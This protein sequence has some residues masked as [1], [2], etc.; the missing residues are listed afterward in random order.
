VIEGFYS[1]TGEIIFITGAET[2]YAPDALRIIVNHF[3]DPTV[4][5]A[6]GTMRVGNGVDRLSTKLETAYRSL[7]DFIRLAEG[8]M[9]APFDIKGEIAASRR[10]VCQHLVEN[11]E[12]ARKG[13]ID[14]SV[15]FQAKKDGY[16]TVYE[17]RAVY[18]EPTPETVKD[19]FKQ[20][21]RRAATLIQNMHI[22]KG[23]M[24]KRK[25]GLFGMLIMPAHLLMLQVLPFLFFLAIGSFIALAVMNPLNI[26][27]IGF[28]VAALLVLLFSRSVQAFAKTQAALAVACFKMLKGMETQKFERLAS[29]RPEAPLLVNK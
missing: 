21:T 4:G 11:K 17:P 28:L 2:Q 10:S 8:N 24:F 7:Y 23:L 13:C 16:R 12:M 27:L 22:F 9:D 26:L 18:Y 15:N 29:V 5:A 3:A 19:S 6:N 1:T 25:Y 14:A 20:Q